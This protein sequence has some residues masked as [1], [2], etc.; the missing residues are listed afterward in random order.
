MPSSIHTDVVITRDQF[1]NI[2]AANQGVALFKFG[3]EWCGPC[4]KV[5]P[6]LKQLY[7]KLP[8]NVE[9]FVLDV[10]DCFD[11]YSFL[12]HKKQVNAV[13]CILAYLRGNLSFAPNISYIGS[14]TSEI[15]QLFDLIH[16][17]AQA[18][19]AIL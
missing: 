7:E 8:N 10:D 9:V 18:A 14:E 5:D 15:L 12:K 1:A 6:L 2:L 4:K 3:A 19:A 13:P 17:Q 16:K 11:L